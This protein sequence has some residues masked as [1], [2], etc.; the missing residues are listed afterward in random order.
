MLV[1]SQS[2]LRHFFYP[3]CPVNKLTDGPVEFTLLN[4]SIVLW[5]DQNNQPAAAENRCCHRWAKLTKG[6][7]INGAIHCPYHGWAFDNTGN[8]I[9]IPQHP[10]R[11]IPSNYCI[12]SYKC[13]SRYDYVWVALEE[14]I[15][16][17]PEIPEFESDEY[18]IIH[19]DNRTWHCSS[20][21]ALENIFDNAHHHFIHQYLGDKVNPVPIPPTKIENTCYGM[22]FKSDIY[23]YSND[24]QYKAWNI[25]NEEM[26]LKREFHWYMPFLVKITLSLP[27]NLK[28]IT[29]ISFT[30]MTNSSLQWINLVIRNDTEEDVKTSDVIQLGMTISYEDQSILENVLPDVPLNLLEQ[31]HMESDRPSILI[32]K[33]FGDLLS[34][35]GDTEQRTDCIPN[36]LDEQISNHTRHKLKVY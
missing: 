3:V 24:L 22:F 34:E 4:Q 6:K 14:P 16:P 12:K 1:A 15:M 20:L 8:C 30:P 18:R 10:E 23:N 9:K 11:P 5:L 31:R 19:L 2:A 21:V 25:K 32:R 26:L 7:V 17:I 27:N 13:Q 35:F 36:K 29:L 28:N 33:R